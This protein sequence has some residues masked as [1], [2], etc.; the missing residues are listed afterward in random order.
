LTPLRKAFRLVEDQ[1]DGRTT[2]TPASLATV[3]GIL[4]RQAM[5]AVGD[6]TKLDLAFI[7]FE[8]TDFEHDARP[9]FRVV[10]DS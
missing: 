1:P 8:G 9:R 10:K 7:D 2:V 6:G 3:L 4:H 5:K